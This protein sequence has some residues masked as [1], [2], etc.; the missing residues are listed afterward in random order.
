MRRVMVRNPE[1]GVREDTDRARDIAVERGIDVRDSSEPGDAVALAREAA[2]EADQILV[3]G[4]DGTVNEVVRGVDDAGNL[5]EV[6]LA[7]VPTGTGNNY[8]NNV[9]VGSVEEAFEIANDGERRRLDLGVADGRL[10]VN[11]CL[12]GLIAEASEHTSSDSKRRFGS[13]AYALQTLT[14]AREFDGTRLDITA[15]GD[16]DEHWSGEAV[17]LLVGNG[18]RF[19]DRGRGQGNVE[20]GL[21]E[22][23]VVE[24]A[25]ATDY[26]AEGVL[27]RLIHRETPHLT[28]LTAERLD[29]S[30]LGEGMAFSLDGETVER[31]ELA[32]RVRER[33]LRVRVGEA[34]EPT[35]PAWPEE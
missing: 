25:S 31:E 6:E 7:V 27:D 3:C 13:L 15:F 12:G 20:D 16:S 5:D 9:G 4:G 18:R 23:V 17:V 24:R 35:P 30:T 2:V 1:S 28:R 21:L 32:I 19:F 11:S 34:Y 8:A 14:D 26:L 33:E 29:V 22:V 10:F